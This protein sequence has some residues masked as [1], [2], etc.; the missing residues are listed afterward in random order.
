VVA[1]EHIGAQRLFNAVL[2]VFLLLALFLF[3]CLLLRSLGVGRL[4]FG[5]LSR[6]LSV[7]LFGLLGFLLC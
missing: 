7:F 5:A 4:N 6:R 1:V 3:L 2:F